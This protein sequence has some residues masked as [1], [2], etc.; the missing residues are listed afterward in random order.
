MEPLKVVR[1]APS[2]VSATEAAPEKTDD[3][4]VS[5]APAPVVAVSVTS[6]PQESEQKLRWVGFIQGCSLEKKK[7]FLSSFLS[8]LFY[9]QLS[10]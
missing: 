6:A 3:V 8:F 1:T 7:F 10:L 4:A 9:D 5:V 2:D